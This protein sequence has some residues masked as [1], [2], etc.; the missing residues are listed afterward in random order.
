MPESAVPHETRNRENPVLTA[1]R[2]VLGFV[3]T[4]DKF[5][6]AGGV[7]VETK[8]AEAPPEAQRRVFDSYFGL[9]ARLR[10]GAEYFRDKQAA[11]GLARAHVSEGLAGA[12]GVLNDKSPHSAALGVV[13]SLLRF[14]DGEEF[15]PDVDVFMWFLS[16]PVAYREAVDSMSSS[17]EVE[18]TDRR[19]LHFRGAVDATPNGHV[20]EADL[21]LVEEL[22]A[23][24]SGDSSRGEE[25]AGAEN[26]PIGSFEALLVAQAAESRGEKGGGR[27][28]RK[29]GRP[30]K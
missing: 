23:A 3:D 6:Q 18:P 1:E 5:L 26:G 28:D 9:V 4:C 15:R 30:E 11:C 8:M 22:R 24:V 25:P 14:P 20:G 29:K 19:W 16:D 2:T 27:R 17:P 12:V 13:R 21:T 7:S 10:N